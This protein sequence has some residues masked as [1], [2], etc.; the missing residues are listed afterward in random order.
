MLTVLRT[1][2]YREDGLRLMT[3][4]IVPV[5]TAIQSEATV[6]FPARHWDGGPHVDLN[7]GYE[8]LPAVRLAELRTM[9]SAAADESA[10]WSPEHYQQRTRRLA[11]LEGRTTWQ[12]APHPH[13]ATEVETL[14]DQ[15]TATTVL[16]HRL[17][18]GMALLLAALPSG[19]AAAAR[20][21]APGLALR[22]M[23]AAASV[24]PGGIRFGSLS[25]RSHA[26][27]F[28]A[29]RPDGAE[30]RARFAAAYERFRPQ[31][32]RLAE[33]ALAEPDRLP[34][35]AQCRAVYR[36]LGAPEM[37]TEIDALLTGT[38]HR[39]QP[40]PAALSAFHQQ[41]AERGF[42][43]HEPEGYRPF[44]VLVNWLYE[45]LQWLGVTPLNRYLYC[46]CLATVIDDRL[47]ERWQDRI[48][49]RPV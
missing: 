21:Q 44:R 19:D 39:T 2:D 9:L 5:L 36:E 29:S 12:P 41:L 33:L 34:G 4:G 27:A 49:V 17:L 28:L 42:G 1:Y 24:Y 48:A 35:H 22:W 16:R 32:E 8:P 31:L 7:L 38:A 14:P 25:F 18:T 46:H 26:E 11:A 6:C 37:R 20:A 47:G 40:A 43:R 10:T 30:Q 3:D 23:A 45:A 15:P 13:G